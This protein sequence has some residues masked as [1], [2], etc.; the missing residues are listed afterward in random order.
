MRGQ[1]RTIRFERS[2]L[3]A[4]GRLARRLKVRRA[5]VVRAAV[6]ELLHGEAQSEAYI[7][8]RQQWHAISAAREA[9]AQVRRE[10]EK[11][12]A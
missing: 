4:A 9:L 11:H 5:D 7:K 6:V 3:E 2:Q 10:L 8:E 1:D 12:E